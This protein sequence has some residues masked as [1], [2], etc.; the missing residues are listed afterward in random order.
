MA[1]TSIE[2]FKKAGE[3]PFL[4]RRH[5]LR[6]VTVGGHCMVRWLVPLF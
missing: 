2:K 1:E 5:P 3:K 4:P 6:Q